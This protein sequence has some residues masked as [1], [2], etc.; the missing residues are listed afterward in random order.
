[1]LGQDGH[2]LPPKHL[3]L[4]MMDIPVDYTYGAIPEPWGY[5]FDAFT[6]TPY[7]DFGYADVRYEN[8]VPYYPGPA[9]G[10]IY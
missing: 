1:M 7:N 10:Y 6:D 3:G 5:G 8:P 9:Y 4:Q 2:G